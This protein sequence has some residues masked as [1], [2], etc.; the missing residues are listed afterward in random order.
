MNQESVEI[1]RGACEAFF[2]TLSVLHYMGYD[3]TEFNSIFREYVDYKFASMNDDEIQPPDF[4]YDLPDEA[5]FVSEESR[6]VKKGPYHK[7]N[8]RDF[9]E[10]W[11]ELMGKIEVAKNEK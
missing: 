11:D 2:Q 5:V 7:D 1:M 3:I 6:N 4:R 8:M 10:R 9:G